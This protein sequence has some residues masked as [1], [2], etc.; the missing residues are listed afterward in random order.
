MDCLHEKP[1]D[2]YPF[3]NH[4]YYV[5]LTTHA[6]SHTVRNDI[7]VEFTKITKRKIMKYHDP[8]TGYIYLIRAY[9]A[10]GVDIENRENTYMEIFSARDPHKL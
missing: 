4:F 2:P 6:V 9:D 8:E 10:T 5:D 7:F 3:E 1:S